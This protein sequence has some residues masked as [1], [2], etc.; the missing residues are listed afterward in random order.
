MCASPSKL[1]HKQSTRSPRFTVAACVLPEVPARL[2]LYRLAE[3][4]EPQSSGAACPHTPRE[5]ALHCLCF[6]ESGAPGRQ[7]AR[8]ARQAAPAVPGVRSAAQ[9]L[10]AR[11][12]Q[13]RSAGFPRTRSTP[14]FP[15]TTGVSG[16]SLGS[17]AIFEEVKQF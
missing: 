16:C 14:S 8:P 17:T 2:S 3:A 6:W 1:P 10:C 4:A 9:Q 11:C 12:F 5:V 7:A 15:L 13:L